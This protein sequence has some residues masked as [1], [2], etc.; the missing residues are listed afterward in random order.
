MA[1]PG[2]G[3]RLAVHSRNHSVQGAEK[4]A[5]PGGLR[6]AV[7]SRN[8]SV[9]GAEKVAGPGDAQASCPFTQPFGSGDREGGGAGGGGRSG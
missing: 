6:L 9:Q 5:G 2:G 8:H 4:V 7:H 1:G 3:L